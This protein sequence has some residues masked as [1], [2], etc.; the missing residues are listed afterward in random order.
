MKPRFLSSSEMHPTQ[1][2]LQFK[3]EM[4]VIWGYVWAIGHVHDS[5]QSKFVDEIGCYIS[6]LW[7]S[8]LLMETH[9]LLEHAPSLVL[10]CVAKVFQ[11]LTVAAHIDCCV[12]PAGMN[13]PNNNLFPSQNM[14][15]I[16]LLELSCFLQLWIFSLTRLLFHFWCC[17]NG[18][19]S[20]L[21]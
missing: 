11:H 18:P 16:T 7:R 20:C 19:R 9:S 12:V 15:T 2:L 10:N 8:I 3:T 14:L 17:V 21:Q 4:V 13:L 6:D 5:I 1:V